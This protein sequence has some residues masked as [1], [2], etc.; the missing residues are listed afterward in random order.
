VETTT[1]PADLPPCD[2]AVFRDGRP[3]LA[4]DTSW[5]ADMDVDDLVFGEH[6]TA[7]RAAGFEAWVC[8][9]REASGQRVDWHMSGGR[10]Q[11][12]YL[13]DRA[14]IEA[15]IEAN[16]SPAT[17][18]RWFSDGDAGLWRNHAR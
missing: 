13:G 17:V 2:P 11:V 8:R 16:P 4:A 15:A 7:P 14:A 12:L 9:I 5:P 6:S 18:L 10:A 1:M 3:L